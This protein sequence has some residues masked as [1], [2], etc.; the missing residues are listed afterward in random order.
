[1]NSVN[2]VGRLG[3][4]PQ[5]RQTT[6]GTPVASVSLAVPRGKETTWVK[7]VLWDKLAKLAESLKKGSR[8]AV[9]G[10]LQVRQFDKDGQTREITEVNVRNLDFLDPRDGNS[11]H[12]QGNELNDEIPF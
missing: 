6:G 2:L 5:I 3:Q 10:E 7:L 11:K 12:Y 8:I 1:M 4:D 9:S